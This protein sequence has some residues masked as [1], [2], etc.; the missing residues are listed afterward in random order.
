MLVAFRFNQPVAPAEVLSHLALN[1]EPHDW[2]RP[3]LSDAGRARLRTNNPQAVARFDAKVA[4]A[5]SAAASIAPQTFALAQDWDKKR[6]PPAA[7]LVVVEITSPV[8]T[9]SWIRARIDTQLRGVEGPALPTK[10][11][12]IRIEAEETFFVSSSAAAN[13]ILPIGTPCGCGAAASISSAFR[14]RCRFATSRMPPAS[15]S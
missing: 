6:F 11:Q 4:A 10:P 9:E 14:R 12:T 1:F 2:D 7:D 3:Q 5:A 13:A 15:R 8:P